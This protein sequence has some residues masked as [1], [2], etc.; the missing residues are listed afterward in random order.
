MLLGKLFYST[1][2]SF[3][4]PQ[5]SL[6]VSYLMHVL[7]FTMYNH[8]NHCPIVFSCML[9]WGTIAM[10]LLLYVHWCLLLEV[11]TVSSLPRRKSVQQWQ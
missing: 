7:S 2:K 6:C 11:C 10:W 9:V 3:N 8:L 4:H 5:L 1:L